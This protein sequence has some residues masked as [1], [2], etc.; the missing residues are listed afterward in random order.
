MSRD[1]T[2]TV[3]TRTEN[4]IV[5]GLDVGSS[6][7]KVVIGE[8]VPDSDLPNIVGVGESDSGDEN[9]INAGAVLNVRRAAARV[10][11]RP[12]RPVFRSVRSPLPGKNGGPAAGTGP[13]RGRG[14]VVDCP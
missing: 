14:S 7:I 11:T 12:R 10:E 2:G 6:K 3:K 8:I 13:C 4:Q 5:V 9:G 1:K